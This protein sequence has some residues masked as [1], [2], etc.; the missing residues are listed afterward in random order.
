MADVEREDRCQTSVAKVY[1]W[2]SEGRWRKIRSG[3]VPLPHQRCPLSLFC[4]VFSLIQASKEPS[5]LSSEHFN[6]TSGCDASLASRPA[7]LPQERERPIRRAAELQDRMEAQRFRKNLRE[8]EEGEGLC[9]WR[10]GTMRQRERTEGESTELK[11]GR[12]RHE[13]ERSWG[14]GVKEQEKGGKG[15]GIRQVWN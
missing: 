15:N 9:G 5:C 6:Q 1:L 11:K 10:G 12:K 14:G 2:W 7:P 3:Q 13:E 8:K 4:F